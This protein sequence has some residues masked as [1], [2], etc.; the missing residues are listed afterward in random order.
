MEKVIYIVYIY[1]LYYKSKPCYQIW[2][3][4]LNYCPRQMA[5]VY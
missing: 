3:A 2:K 4:R 5:N 1:N